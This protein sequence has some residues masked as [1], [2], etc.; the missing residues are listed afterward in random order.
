[1]TNKMLFFDQ[2]QKFTEAYLSRRRRIRRIKREK[3]KKKNPLLDWVEA[4]LWAAGVVLLINQYLLQAYQ[5][6]S[7]SMI[8]TLLIG[9]RIFVNKILYGPELLP[10]LG[11]LPS[12]IKPKRNDIIIFENPSYISRG[13]AFDIAQ[14][15]IYMLTLSFVD[16]DRDEAGE[17]KAHFLIKRAVGVAGDRFIMDKGEFRIRFAGEDRWVTEREYA[18]GRNFNYHI[19]RLM[20]PSD[21][22]AL[23]AAGK[24]TA[25]NNLGLPSPEHL[26]AAA[27]AARDWS[28]PDYLYHEQC[29]LELLRAAHPED[30]R[31]RLA[32][33][34]YIQ[35][36]YIPE[37]R[38]FPL[39]D[40]RDNSRD[41]RYFN[42]VRL[43]KVLGKGSVIYWPLR[44][45]GLIR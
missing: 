42:P 10:G 36:W 40:N 34:R 9:D 25:Y 35:G 12:P 24:L 8:D 13:P 38:I 29:R 27:T 16:I 19:S 14:R 20:E 28:Y 23:A 33:A 22:P 37:G 18:V 1:M 7:G 5:I 44:R 43:S 4:F 11:K 17:P 41:G 32:L 45:I 30:E 21:Y 6:P 15:I 2:V 39:G 31:Y 3:Q 26:I